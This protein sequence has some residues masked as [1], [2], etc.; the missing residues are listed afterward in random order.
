[1]TGLL[2]IDDEEGVRQ[3]IR[4]ALKREPYSIHTAENGATV[5][6]AI[7]EERS[8]ITIVI[9]DY[10]MPGPDGLDTLARIVSINPEV[11]RV[12]FKGCAT[13]ES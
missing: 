13:M 9:S 12:L 10:K 8:E 5:I 11:T 2:F 1:M 3:S 6:K 7:Q 4:R